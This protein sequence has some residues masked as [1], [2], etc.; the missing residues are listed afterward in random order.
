VRSSSRIPQVPF[1]KIS[2]NMRKPGQIMTTIQMAHDYMVQ[3]AG[4]KQPRIAVAGLNPH[5][6][7]I[8]GD[9]EV[10]IIKPVIDEANANGYRC[11]GPIPPDTCFMRAVNGEFDVVIAMYHDQGHIPAKLSE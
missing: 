2:E 4:V 10:K 5:C 7:P 3:M 11:F 6:E 8:F 9:Q 1:D